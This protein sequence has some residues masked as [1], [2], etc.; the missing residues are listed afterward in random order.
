MQIM[1]VFVSQDEHSVADLARRLGLD[2]ARTEW[3]HRDPS[4]T[5]DWQHTV[6]SEQLWWDSY[7]VQTG[8]LAEAR[9]LL[10]ML[11]GEGRARRLV[12]IISGYSPA[13]GNQVWT[14]RSLQAKAVTS[15]MTVPGVGFAVT[16]VGG[17]WVNI[18]AAAV[19]ALRCCSEAAGRPVL[20]G[21]R[22][23]I[24]EAS[25]SPWIAGDIQG[26]FMTDEL[27]EPDQDD[28]YSVDVVVG[29]AELAELPG[30][31]TPPIWPLTGEMLPPVDTAIFSPMGFL[32]IP[33]KPAIS[34]EPHSVSNRRHLTE[35]DVAALRRHDYLVID[36]ARFH[37]LD[38]PLARRMTQLAV[39]G[40]P[41]L[42]SGLSRALRSLVEERL[43]ERIEAFTAGDSH[44]LRESKSIDMRRSAL[45]LYGPTNRWNNVLRQLGRPLAPLTSVSVLLAS[46]RPD[47]LES[48]FAQLGRQS[49]NAVEVVLA[50]HGV[51]PELPEVKRAIA[52]YP[53]EVKVCSLPASMVFGNVLNNAVSAASGDLVTKI[54]DDDWYGEHHIRDL[55]HAK[56]YSGAT[57]VGA[58]VE[59]VYLETL[60]ITTRRPPSG[61][62]FSDHVAGGTMTIGRDDLR[63]LGGWRP[64]HRAVDRCLL[65]AVHA[66]GGLVYRSHGQSY[67]MHRHSNADSHGGHTWN[68]D[69]SVFLQ[70]VAEQWDGFRPPPQI[71]VRQVAPAAERHSSLRSHFTES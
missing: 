60:D 35:A 11:R 25:A 20:K 71:D 37:G 22:V 36:G 52:S 3:Q 70:S 61:E 46:R 15:A 43:V 47:K 39:A 4:L 56:E 24:T 28:I 69:D 7:V 64:V 59:F 9:S 51:D 50:L 16:I 31:Q 26:S 65:Q 32:P 33:D 53:G 1:S 2:Y 57:M 13:G 14:S 40:V 5:S 68:P 45:E 34:L 18:H 38:G 19:A 55:V 44:L 27:L 41:M 58:Q 6:P 48:A 62:R 10:P 17:K 66:A 8:S 54:D 49:W 67:L 21:L 12:L 30:R 23:G 29:S 42:V 63:E